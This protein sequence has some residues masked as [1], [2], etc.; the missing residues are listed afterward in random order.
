[1]GD[2]FINVLLTGSSL[3]NASL[4]LT[5]CKARS[6]TGIE[7]GEGGVEDLMRRKMV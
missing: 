4:S 5:K 2:S 3:L 6:P 7:D 1:M